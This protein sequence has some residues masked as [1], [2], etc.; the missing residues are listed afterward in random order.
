MWLGGIRVQTAQGELQTIRLSSAP[1][2][3]YVVRLSLSYLCVETHRK[4][5][6]HSSLLMVEAW[7][8]KLRTTEFSYYTQERV[9][10]VSHGI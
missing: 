5:P 9:Y 10:S 1:H 2:N 3:S 7:S 4:L 8:A 6:S